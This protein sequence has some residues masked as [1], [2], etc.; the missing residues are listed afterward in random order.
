[1]MHDR[2]STLADR[3]VPMRVRLAALWT[4]A[5]G[6][7]VYGDLISHWVPAVRALMSSG[8]MGPLGAVTPELLL[9]VAGF[10]SIPM[11]MIALT[12]LLRA[13]WARWLNV[14]VGAAYSLPVAASLIGAGAY[15]L[16][17]TGISL[18]CTASIAWLAWSWPREAAD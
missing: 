13:A 17:L 3:P 12:V 8:Q 4:A 14:V 1:M 5:L 18:I 16:L 7:Y 10:M 6:C 11:L 9:G 15:Y 2:G